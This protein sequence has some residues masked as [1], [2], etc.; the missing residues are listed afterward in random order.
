MLKI[1]ALQKRMGGVIP[2]YQFE[3]LHELGVDLACLPEYFFLPDRIRNQVDTADHRQRHLDA[4]ETFSRRMVGIVVGGSLVEREG[5]YYYNACHVFDNGRYVGFYRKTHPTQ[6]EREVGIF[7]G[8][9]YAVLE[10]RGIRLGMLICADVL[11]SDGYKALADL[12]PHVIA[13]P[14]TSPFQPNETVTQK[15]Q[16]DEDLFVSGARETGAYIL[17]ACGVG[18]L[19]GHRL[20]GRSLIC[21]PRGI[22][23]RVKPRNEALEATLIETV[24]LDEL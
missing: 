20:Q 23:S 12:K 1:A 11:F 6:R 10:V 16:R 7:P 13:V 8:S 19:M 17:K 15:F 21:S 18:L 24:N 5:P 9:G 22:I 4:I 3:R 2:P 14:T